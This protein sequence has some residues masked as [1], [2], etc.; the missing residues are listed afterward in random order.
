MKNLFI[1]PTGRVTQRA[2]RDIGM[3]MSWMRGGD[4]SAKCGH[5]M[6]SIPQ[7]K[8]FWWSA[9]RRSWWSTGRKYDADHSVN[10]NQQKLEHQAAFMLSTVIIE[11]KMYS[12]AV[13][14]SHYPFHWLLRF[15]RAFEEEVSTGSFSAY[16]K[17]N[18]AVLIRDALVSEVSKHELSFQQ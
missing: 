14:L 3:L 11:R 10:Q 2:D 16:S 5:K 4:R 15:V 6:G 7:M 13:S 12:W 1:S 17:M 9:T 8:T 18:H